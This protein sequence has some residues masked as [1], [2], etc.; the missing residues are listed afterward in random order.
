[1][2]LLGVD[3]MPFIWARPVVSFKYTCCDLIMFIGDWPA[4]FFKYTC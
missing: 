2:H 3:L 1:M 4:D